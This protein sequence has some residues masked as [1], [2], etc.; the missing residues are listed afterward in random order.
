MTQEE[1]V[2]VKVHHLAIQTTVD[3][4]QATQTT[5]VLHQDIRV[6]C[7]LAAEDHLQDILRIEVQAANQ[8]S[9]AHKASALHKV[10]L[11]PATCSVINEPEIVKS[12][13][14]VTQHVFYRTQ[15]LSY[16]HTFII[17]LFFMAHKY[18]YFKIS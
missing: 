9:Q 12:L 4:H 13:Q 5:V 8:A 7:H 11:A 1:L 3:H 2:C 18:Y 10:L 17:N 15:V 6:V 14:F 16:A